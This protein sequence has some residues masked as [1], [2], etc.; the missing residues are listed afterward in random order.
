MHEQAYDQ[1]LR[2]PAGLFVENFRTYTDT[3]NGK[4]VEQAGPRP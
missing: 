2:R 1:A 3:E 4:L